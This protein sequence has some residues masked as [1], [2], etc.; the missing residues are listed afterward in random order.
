MSESKFRSEYLYFSQRKRKKNASDGDQG[1][2]KRNVSYAS[3]LFY[4]MRL[5]LI[6]FI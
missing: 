1:K 3:F 2:T 4:F 5:D 6:F